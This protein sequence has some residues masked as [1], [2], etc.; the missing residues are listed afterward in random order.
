M[1]RASDIELIFPIK[2]AASAALMVIKA[3]CVRGFDGH[4][5]GLPAQRWRY[6]RGGEAVGLF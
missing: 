4:K 1:Q 6:Q 5:G 2:D 3:D